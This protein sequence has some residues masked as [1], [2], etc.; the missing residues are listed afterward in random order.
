[1]WFLPNKSPFLSPGA[2]GTLFYT[3]PICGMAPEKL[4]GF[5]TELVSRWF[6]SKAIKVSLSF[7]I[8]SLVLDSEATSVE[9]KWSAEVG[10]TCFL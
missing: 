9:D 1:M 7:V 6:S 4:I 2:R 3:P 10:E 8:V 5:R